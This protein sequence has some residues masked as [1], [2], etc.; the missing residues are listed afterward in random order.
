VIA[1]PWLRLVSRDW[2]AY[3]RR[4]D[5]LFSLALRRWGI[6][7][8]TAV[9][10][11]MGEG[12]DF[13]RWAK[14]KG[15]RVI[16]E[17]FVNPITHR[18]L[19]EERRRWPGWEDEDPVDFSVLERDIDQRIKLADILI[20]PSYA[21]VEG[22]QFY[23]SFSVDKV[24]VVPY[25]FPTQVAEGLVNPE[26]GR[27]LFGGAANLNKGIQYFAEAAR[28][29]DGPRR[30]FRFRVAGD[31]TERIR[32][33]PETQGLE[34]LGRLPWGKFIEELRLTDVL[35]LPTLAEGSAVVIYEALACGVPVVTT[36][37]AGS[38]VTDGVEGRIVPERDARALAEA[39]E[40]IVN[41]RDLRKRMSAAALRTA[42]AYGEDSWRDRLL[43]ALS[44]PSAA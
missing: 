44:Q 35:V 24:R 4:R 25:A 11:M 9:Y 38:V 29:L 27:V 40:G 6:G 31:V 3:F 8:A 37:S 5:K 30:Q 13:L 10:S 18:I 2:Y 39:I 16:L 34:F 36:R 17:V 12:L 15:L 19:R 20:C 21:V 43:H 22:L 41:D 33:R 28:M 26:R 32:S 42:A 23:P 1:E 14:G 7:K